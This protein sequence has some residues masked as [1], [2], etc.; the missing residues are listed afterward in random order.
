M[1]SIADGVLYQYLQSVQSYIA[2]PI[3]AVFLLGIFSKRINSRGAMA[4]LISGMVIA[5]IRLTLEI[6]K[7]SFATDSFFY[8]LG[9][10]NFLHFSSWFFLVAVLTTIIVS[11]ATPAQ[12]EKDIEGLSMQTVS[13]EDRQANKDTYN[14]MDIAASLFV[15][16]VVAY[17]MITFS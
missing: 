1:Q 6:T 4:A 3:T 15:I 8:K 7:D 2:P 13:A 5:V 14:W 17:V 16:A 12:N 11:L 9:D 10:M